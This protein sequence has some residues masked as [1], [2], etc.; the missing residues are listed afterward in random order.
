VLGL[1]TDLRG[2]AL[3]PRRHRLTANLAGIA[4]N[5]AC[6]SALLLARATPA[7]GT[8]PHRFLAAALLFALLPLPFQLMVFTRTD[9]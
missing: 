4:H 5:R 9:V 3:A 8:A 6:A 2:H 1:Q 7:P